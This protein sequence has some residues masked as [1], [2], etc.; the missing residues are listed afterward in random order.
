MKKITLYASLLL[1]LPATYSLQAMD[2]WE[3]AQQG[4]CVMIEKLIRQE[5]GI[6]INQADTNGYTPLYWAAENSHTKA[7]QL[8]LELGADI[9]QAD[10]NGYTPLLLAAR[11][12]PAD[13]VQ[14]LIDLG[15]DINTASQ[16]GYTPLHE[17]AMYNHTEVVQLLLEHGADINKANKWDETP[18]TVA[19]PEAQKIIN[20]FIQ[21]Q[22][23]T[24]LLGHHARCGTNSQ[25]MQLPPFVLNDIAQLA[26]VMALG[27]ITSNH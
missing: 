7:V 9:N 5:K 13:V 4:N 24:L 11:N 12:D 16:Y 1:L 20:D 10:N 23:T 2:L 15:A 17:A 6:D 14:L 3:A 26:Y 27:K 18:L 8:L 19:T 25:L 21:K 22:V